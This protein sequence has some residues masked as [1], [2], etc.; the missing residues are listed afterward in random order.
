MF[1][2][3]VEELLTKNKN[4]DISIIVLC[5]NT[6]YSK[7][8]PADRHPHNLLYT[9]TGHKELMEDFGIS[10]LQYSAF[11]WAS[12]QGESVNNEQRFLFTTQVTFEMFWM[13][14]MPVIKGQLSPLCVHKSSVVNSLTPCGFY[15]LVF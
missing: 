6:D 7:H 9:T 1:K 13:F 8:N 11:V 15:W 12:E 10:G 5:C 2:K 14:E 4:S 3:L